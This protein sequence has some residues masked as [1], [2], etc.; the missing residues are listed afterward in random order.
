M[1]RIAEVS[2]LTG[3]VRVTEKISAA[4]SATAATAAKQPQNCGKNAQRKSA[5][6]EQIFGSFGRP[7][8]AQVMRRCVAAFPC[9][10]LPPG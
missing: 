9:R 3:F 8:A 10:P 2:A 7:G 4:M 1:R 5:G 6:G